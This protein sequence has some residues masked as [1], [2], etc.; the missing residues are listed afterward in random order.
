MGTKSKGRRGG[1]QLG[2]MLVLLAGACGEARSEEGDGFGLSVAQAVGYDD[3]LYRL[4]PGIKAERI[5]APGRAD[6]YSTT[7]LGAV[8][9][10]RYSRQRVRME[11]NYGLVRYAESD[12]LDYESWK[13]SARLDS[14]FGNRWRAS[15]GADT[16][17]RLGSFADLP[18]AVRNLVTDNRLSASAEFQLESDW[19][20]SGGLSH[21][22]SRNSSEIR[23]VNDEDRSQAQIGLSFVSRRGSSAAFTL[24]RLEG[25]LANRQVVGS[26]LVDNSYQQT[27]AELSAAW[28]PDGWGTWSAR[29][30]RVNR[31]HDEVPARDFSGYTARLAYDFR[32]TGKSAIGVIVR[33]EIGAEQDELTNYAVT[34]GLTVTTSWLPTAKLRLDALVEGRWREQQGDPGFFAAAGP[35]PEDRYVIWSLAASYQALLRASARIGIQGDRRSSNY[36]S[37]EY[38]AT[39]LS[40]SFQMAF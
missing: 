22:T 21:A 2:L 28:E 20:I 11:A 16:A 29:V 31:R 8:F 37:R 5:G 36:P 12:F 38:R 33:R 34:Q 23:K 26:A 39:T 3:N 18:G 4:A 9:D 30:A 24:R 19:K 32:A 13:G 6:T 7:S 25:S 35:R 40:A 10:N 17:R 1:P 14:E 27:D 15:F